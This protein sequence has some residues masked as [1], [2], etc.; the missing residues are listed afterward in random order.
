MDDTSFLLE[1]IKKKA[2]I[3]DDFIF[4][5]LGGVHQTLNEA[6]A[7]LIKAGGKRLRPY[8]A[9]TSYQIF[10]SDITKIL[11]FASALE[12]LHTFTLIHDDIMDNDDLRRGLPTVHRVWGLSMAIL[13]GDYLFA[14]VFQLAS[15]ANV[16]PKISVRAIKEISETSVI[17]CDGQAYDLSFE[18]REIV[19]A[20]E[21]FDMI[22]KKTAALF[23]AS[24]RLGGIIADADEEH[25][26][27]LGEF[28][29][30]IGVAFQIIDDII[31]LVGEEK[32]TGKPRGSDV[33]EGKKTL[34]ILYALNNLSSSELEFLKKMLKPGVEKSKDDIEKAVNLIEKAG[35]IEFSRN[36]ARKIYNEAIEALKK[37]PKNDAREELLK[38]SIV[39]VERNF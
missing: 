5:N 4:K 37:L 16:D 21:Y 17:I 39:L 13:A 36:Y 3:V 26:K 23:R 31:G 25:I 2:S 35:G 27:N 22:S 10:D 38:F 9:I 19:S 7:H 8:L 33:R 30:K 34:P 6:S 15:N 14:K 28:G 24:T 1:Q 32:V 12:V 18:E 29:F 11:P 20:D